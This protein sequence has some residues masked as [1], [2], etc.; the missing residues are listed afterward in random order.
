[1]RKQSRRFRKNNWRRMCANLKP[2][3]SAAHR[4]AGRCI[5]LFEHTCINKEPYTSFFHDKNIPSL[6]FLFPSIPERL[7]FLSSIK[8]PIQPTKP[9]IANNAGIKIDPDVSAIS[10]Y[11]PNMHSNRLPIKPTIILARLFIL[12]P[13]VLFTTLCSI[14]PLIF[15]RFQRYTP[16]Q[17]SLASLPLPSLGK[18]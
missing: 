7:I 13:P 4:I 3:A 15:R 8:L 14:L 12:I 5:A 10:R 1:M 2:A 18:K 11:T 16:P 6:Y 9:A 17:L